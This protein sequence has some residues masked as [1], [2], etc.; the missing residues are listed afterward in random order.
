MDFKSCRIGCQKTLLI[1]AKGPKSVE[2]SGTSSTRHTFSLFND[3]NTAICPIVEWNQL[4][5]YAI[6]LMAVSRGK[7]RE[8]MLAPSLGESDPIVPECS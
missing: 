3:G 5:R 1:A 7:K 6:D 8:A 4:P 2:W